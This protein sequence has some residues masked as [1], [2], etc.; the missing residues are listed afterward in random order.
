MA[1]SRH[2]TMKQIE[3][4]WDKEKDNTYG[5]WIGT[6]LLISGKNIQNAY[7]GITSED[8][9][10]ECGEFSTDGYYLILNA[11]DRNYLAI[12]EV[13]DSEDLALKYYYND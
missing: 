1:Y 10:S 2:L 6:D 12:Y 13:S 5:V 9:I 3:K 11:D 7:N 8:I 4:I